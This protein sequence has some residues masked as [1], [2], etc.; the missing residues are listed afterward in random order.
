MHGT[1][2]NLNPKPKS[3]R[4]QK[5]TARPK[6]VPLLSLKQKAAR[7]SFA[8]KQLSA[9]WR[10]TMT[11]DNNIFRMHA[12]GKP[13]SKICTTA[14]RGTAGRPKHSL[15]IHVYMGMPYCG[16]TTLRFV[17]GTHKPPNQ[18]INTS[19]PNPTAAS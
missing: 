12:M 6:T 1:V 4:P 3:G 13:A 5:M 16:V 19:I 17:T 9:A 18:S 10:C 7:D 15:V 2:K 8:R 14:T 11:T